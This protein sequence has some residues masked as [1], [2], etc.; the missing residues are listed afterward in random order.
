[1]EIS[2]LKVLAALKADLEQLSQEKAND[3]TA[4][5]E[6]CLQDDIDEDDICLQL[7]GDTKKSSN[8]RVLKHRYESSVVN[9]IF[10]LLDSSPRDYEG[11]NKQ[12]AALKAYTTGITLLKF[13]KRKAAIEVLEKNLSV[14][15][16]HGLMDLILMTLKIL[17]D[18]YSYIDINNKKYDYY[19]KLNIDTLRI[20]QDEFRVK[21]INRIF[22]KKYVE[23]KGLFDKKTLS[24]FKLLIN[25]LK[26]ISKR[27]NSRTINYFS[28]D[29]THFYYSRT[30]DHQ[31]A[32]ELSISRLQEIQKNTPEDKK[33]IYRTKI[34]IALSYFNV[35]M[36]A[37]S[38]NT[39]E[40]ALQLPTRG[41]RLYFHDTSL[42]FLVLLRD[43]QYGKAI[44]LFRE[45][46]GQKT[47]SLYN[48]H[49]EQWIIREAF[50]NLLEKFDC[51]PQDELQDVN[52][53]RF[54]LGKF[55]NSVP[56]YSKDKSGQYVSIL[57]I[58]YL[59]LFLKKKYAEI[60]KF[61]E[62]IYQ[63]SYLYL[64]NDENKRSFLFIKLLV[65]AN[66]YLA[67]YETMMRKSKKVH[68]ELVDTKFELSEDQISIEIVPYELLWNII[69]DKAKSM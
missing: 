67:D 29:L 30:G 26:A 21:Q 32:L 56:F 61:S 31:A 36:I 40:D 34:N 63:Y 38:V 25:E 52:L 33:L 47:L 22:S 18:H 12:V 49:Q 66:N 64:K 28:T 48:D 5:F 1:M 45:V 41:S 53:K 8:F 14:C 55:L 13:N 57:I 7:Y 9:D 10:N 27:S 46:S 37:K 58:K 6:Q 50:L 15:I 43:Q 20:Y 3:K 62:S 39:F 35:N 59:Y 11:N 2:T 65:I 51:I 17:L 19:K 16:K 24:E 60:Y 69:V 4:E 42:Y 54:S 68:D 23:N 44:K